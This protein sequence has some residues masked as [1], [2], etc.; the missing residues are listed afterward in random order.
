MGHLPRSTHE[1]GGLFA[2]PYCRSHNTVDRA[3]TP[4]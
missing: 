1:Q 4:A 3:F 2:R